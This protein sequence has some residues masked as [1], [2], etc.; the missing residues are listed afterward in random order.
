VFFFLEFV[1]AMTGILKLQLNLD[2]KSKESNRTED[3]GCSQGCSRKN[4]EKVITYKLLIYNEL[5]NLG[6]VAQLVEQRPF[7]P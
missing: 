2:I 6:S 3:S 1:L 4:R 7:K 5:L